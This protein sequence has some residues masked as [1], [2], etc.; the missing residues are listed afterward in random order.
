MLVEPHSLYS[1]PSSI[2]TP[3]I[4]HRHS[5]SWVIIPL[6]SLC[7]YCWVQHTPRPSSD[8]LRQLASLPPS[9]SIP[10][11]SKSIFPTPSQHSIPKSAGAPFIVMTW[12]CYSWV[13]IGATIISGV[14]NCSSLLLSLFLLLFLPL[15]LLSSSALFMSSQEWAIQGWGLDKQ[16]ERPS[17]R[18]RG[19]TWVLNEKWP[20]S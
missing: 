16:K 12:P 9:P 15:L 3:S 13:T 11:V 17:Q 7:C 14:Q 19:P 6:S 1:F 10:F 5:R 8:M 20:R 2:S 4:T 18:G